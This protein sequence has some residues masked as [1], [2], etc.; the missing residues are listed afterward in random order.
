MINLE[1]SRE[2][3]IKRA[4]TDWWINE[5][6]IVG[7]NGKTYIAYMTDMGEIHLKELDAKCNRAP[8]RD[9]TLRRLNCNYADEHNS[10]S[11]CIL[12]DGRM[13]VA[14]TGHAATATLTY[15]ITERPYDIFSFG[16]EIVLEYDSSVT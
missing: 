13:I 16:P 14:Y 11:L 4:N 12:Q 6:A 5:K 9:I 15:R 3:R 8:S 7:E 1:N 2:L 10:P